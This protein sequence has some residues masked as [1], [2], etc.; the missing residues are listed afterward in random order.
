MI[1]YKYEPKSFRKYAQ[2]KIFLEFCAISQVK[3]NKKGANMT[4]FSNMSQSFS[5][6][7]LK[8]RFR[9][10]FAPLRRLRHFVD[11]EK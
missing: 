1:I 2:I 7:M 3:K 8:L 6:N 11:I 9:L 10:I 5:E 4:L